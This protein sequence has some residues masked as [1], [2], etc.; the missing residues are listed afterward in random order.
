MKA[1]N[2]DVTR[3][4]T[5]RPRTS[6]WPALVGALA[7]LAISYSMVY[8]AA[9][10]ARTNE[11]LVAHAEDVETKAAAERAKLL[12]RMDDMD[13][14]LQAVV[15]YFAERGTPIPRWVLTTTTRD[16][17]GSDDSDDSDGGGGSSSPNGRTTTVPKARPSDR[18]TPSRTS[19]AADLTDPVEGTVEDTTET[20]TG[21][22]KD[23]QEQV[24]DLTGQ[25]NPQSDD[26]PGLVGGLLGR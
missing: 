22:T 21:V 11:Q 18:P 25:V 8:A 26:G 1:P 17:P 12:D 24:E 4:V 13:G 19:P 3:N 15:A 20:A 9:S 6:R 14:R 10:T 23:T 16:D 5:M 2:W 7:V